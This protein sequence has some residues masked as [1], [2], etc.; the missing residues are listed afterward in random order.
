MARD[1]ISAMSRCGRGVRHGDVARGIRRRGLLHRRGRLPFLGLRPP[2]IDQPT[3]LG[4]LP[5]AHARRERGGKRH[6]PVAVRALSLVHASEKCPL[7]GD[8][9]VVRAATS[10]GQK[11]GEHQLRRDLALVRSPRQPV[12]S[13]VVGLRQAVSLGVAESEIGLGIGVAVDRL[14]VG[15]PGLVGLGDTLCMRLRHREQQEH[16]TA[17]LG[18]KRSS[19]AKGFHQPPLRRCVTI[20]RR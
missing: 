3:G 19:D 14:P 4:D 1:G 5:T 15:Q 10:G 16:E 6:S 7:V 13:P 17:G 9:I 2:P 8:R 18:K 11:L 20:G 12:H